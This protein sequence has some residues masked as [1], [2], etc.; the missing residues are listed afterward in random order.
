[1]FHTT[2]TYNAEIMGI[3]SGGATDG[4]YS[5]F[6]TISGIYADY[7]LDSSPVGVYID[8]DLK[9]QAYTFCI[10]KNK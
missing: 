7:T 8:G 10:Y 6:S 1:M 2:S 5:L 3:H 4:S 9:D